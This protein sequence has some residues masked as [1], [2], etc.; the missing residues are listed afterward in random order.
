[1]KQYYAWDLDLQMQIAR[2]D[3][4]FN[5]EHVIVQATQRSWTEAQACP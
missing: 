1:M 3:E 4:V 2:L 5:T